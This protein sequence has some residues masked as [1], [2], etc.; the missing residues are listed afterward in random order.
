MESVIVVVQRNWLWM[1]FGYRPNWQLYLDR[2]WSWPFSIS[3]LRKW[4]LSDPIMDML[5]TTIQ[6]L[7]FA[8][9]L[10]TLPFN[11]GWA[12]CQPAGGSWLGT[13]WVISDYEC[14]GHQTLIGGWLYCQLAF[15]QTFSHNLLRI[16][17]S[18]H[19]VSKVDNRRSGEPLLSML[20][21][22]RSARPL[23]NRW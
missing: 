19:M 10:P 23:W 20:F 3:F 11:L 4:K 18:F 5:L 2:I 17:S 16:P 12:S 13:D 9:A 1:K 8:E 15:R 7:A 14:L 22:N 6:V 21:H